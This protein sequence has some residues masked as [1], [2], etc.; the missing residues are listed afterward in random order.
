MDVECEGG[1]ILR[2]LEDVL[3]GDLD[4]DIVSIVS[5]CSGKSGFSFIIF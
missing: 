4:V 2:L 3:F 1:S 5:L